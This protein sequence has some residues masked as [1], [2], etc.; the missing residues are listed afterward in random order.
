MSSIFRAAR[1]TLAQELERF[2]NRHFLEACMAA[3]AKYL[4][5]ISISYVISY[6]LCQ[7]I[8][9]DVVIKGSFIMRC[10]LYGCTFLQNCLINAI[11]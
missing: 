3:S 11:F 6:G 1:E 10:V 4:T 7:R 5:I 9:P 8:S 2:R